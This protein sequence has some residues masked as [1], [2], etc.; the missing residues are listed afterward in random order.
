MRKIIVLI[1]L[2]CCSVVSDSLQ[3]HGLQ[4][5]RL[6]CPSPSPGACFKLMS[7]ESVMP[8]NNSTSYRVVV[9][10]EL[11]NPKLLKPYLE[12]TKYSNN[13]ICYFNLNPVTP[14]VYHLGLGLSIRKSKMAK[15]GIRETLFD[16]QVS[17][18]RVARGA[19][20]L[21][22]TQA[23]SILLLHQH[24]HLVP[25]AA[26]VLASCP[27]SA[28]PPAEAWRQGGRDALSLWD[29]PKSCCTNLPLISHWPGLSYTATG[30]LNGCWEV[31]S[32]LWVSPRS[33]ITTEKKTGMGKTSSL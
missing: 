23:L 27:Y 11:I 18:G 19:P 26:R 17:Y 9:L 4:H 8:S 21:A 3:P 31:E 28:F 32:W 10:N 12:Q 22:G 1:L 25:A 6:P 2:F 30:S 5:T 16:P 15:A 29:P 33:S 14:H 7:I 20:L 24:Q 13:I